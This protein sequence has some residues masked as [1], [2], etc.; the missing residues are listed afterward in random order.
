MIEE[1]RTEEV[2]AEQPE[3]QKEEEQKEIPPIAEFPIP[4]EE[5]KSFV[6]R[7]EDPERRES[8]EQLV[9]NVRQA[10]FRYDEAVGRLS[11][12]RTQRGK[13]REE[14]DDKI[15]FET[16]NQLT[17]ST[18]S[19]MEV[20]R[21]ALNIVSRN[22]KDAQLDNSWRERFVTDQSIGDWALRVVVNRKRE[23]HKTI[24][25]KGEPA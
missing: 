2:R 11:D 5:L 4:F 1:P 15:Y 6:S 22:M 14:S 13:N 12:Y 9:E 10:C 18:M 17:L 25:E 3:N 19:R 23:T 21:D 20:L 16:L 7:I 8:L 24:K